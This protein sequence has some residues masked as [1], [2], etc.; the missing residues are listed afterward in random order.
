MSAQDDGMDVNINIKNL[1]DA[2]NKLTKA[3]N[4]GMDGMASKVNKSASRFEQQLKRIDYAHEKSISRTQERYKLMGQAR[5]MELLQRLGGGGMGGQIMNFI[6]SMGGQKISDMERLRSLKDKKRSK[7]SSVFDTAEIQYLESNKSV[8][9]LE[10]LSKKFDQYFGGDSKWNKMFGGHGKMAATG[11]GIGAA[12]MGVMAV[13]KGVQLAIESSP[14]LQQMLKLWKFGIMMVLR[15]IGTF[16]GMIMRPIM[17]LMLRKFIIPFY[18]K[19]MP[20]MTK[21]GNDLGVFIAKWLDGKTEEDSPTSNE[22]LLSGLDKWINSPEITATDT[23][24]ERNE[25]MD[26][27]IDAIGEV[28]S[29][30][31]GLMGDSMIGLRVL[32]KI[33]ELTGDKIVQNAFGADSDGTEQGFKEEFEGGFTDPDPQAVIDAKLIDAQHEIRDLMQE[34]IDNNPVADAAETIEE[35][36]KRMDEKA[37]IDSD[38]EQEKKDARDKIFSEGNANLDEG[39]AINTTNVNGTYSSIDNKE[40]EADRQKAIIDSYGSMNSGGRKQTSVR[41]D[42]IDGVTG[43]HGL[44]D[45]NGDGKI[46]YLDYMAN[47]GII[48]EPILG[49]GLR[50]GKGY[51][52]GEA[53]KEAVIPL[54]KLGGG[55][56]SSITINIQN[57]SGSQQDLNNL[58]RTILDVLQ[59]SSMGRMRA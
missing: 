55:G 20:V 9:V 39:N 50:T 33:L 40:T 49:T 21:L 46:D 54:N 37:G 47:G 2:I 45:K 6:G 28:L 30:F 53:G 31:A 16:F 42:M 15:P 18:Q 52:M 44:L 59:Q 12:T 35:V 48:D 27:R 29:G 34:Q 7:G 43:G 14:M 26:I 57:M 1:Q 41:Q 22:V 11:M 24:E 4:G 25:K 38:F 51:M 17:L 3:M 32:G 58:K 56:N 13:Q 10:T 19:Y 23:E 8:T 36:I 5:S